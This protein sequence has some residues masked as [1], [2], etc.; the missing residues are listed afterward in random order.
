[1]TAQFVDPVKARLAQIQARYADALLRI[2]AHDA[3]V[4]ALVASLAAYISFESRTRLQCEFANI[5]WDRA[6]FRAQRDLVEAKFEVYEARVR[7]LEA[8]IM[9]RQPGVYNMANVDRAEKAEAA[10]AKAPDKRRLEYLEQRQCTL[11]AQLR[12][13]KQFMKDNT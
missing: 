4:D 13:L 9:R 11:E 5:R 2:A 1:M 8:E 10:L 6:Q 7:E 12:D 3:S